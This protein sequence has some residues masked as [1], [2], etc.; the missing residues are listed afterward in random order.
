[1]QEVGTQ[2]QMLPTKVADAL[3]GHKVGSRVQVEGTAEAIVG[4][5]LNPQ[6]GIKPT[7]PLVWVVDIVN[8]KKVDKKGEVKG[9]QAASE[10][11]MPEV[12][13]ASQKAA[14][15][16]IPKGEK[17]PKDLKEQ[18]LIKGDGAAVKAGEG[19]VVQYT[20]VKWEDGKKFDSSWDHGGASA[21][22]IGVGGVIQGWDKGLVGKNVGDRVLLTIPPNQAY[23][24][25]PSN[26][27]AKNNLVFVVD[28]L[29]TV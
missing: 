15:I 29:G 28:I 18:V 2:G 19:L 11:G 16:T 10:A 12:K 13:A 17:A 25:D 27:L 6:S 20:G 7:D 5:Q 8:A 14:T 24:A 22:P 4:E 26:Q 9:D 1:M 23:G 21:F 3:T